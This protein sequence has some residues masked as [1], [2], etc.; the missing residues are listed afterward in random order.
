MAW[1]YNKD[2]R[3]GG[4]GGGGDRG[5]GCGVTYYLCPRSV[6]IKRQ[7]KRSWHE[8]KKEEGGDKMNACY[9]Q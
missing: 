2:F 5:W 4:G 6:F 7:F 8:M 3:F 1:D 9:I